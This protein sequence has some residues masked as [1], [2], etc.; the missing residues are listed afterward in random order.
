MLV[1]HSTSREHT[2]KRYRRKWRCPAKVGN[3]ECSNPCSTSNYG[4]TFYTS[5]KDNPRLFPRVK[6]DSKEWRTRYALRTGVE[7]CNK[8]QKIDYKL[9]ESKW[10]SSR[11]WTIRTY[12]IAMCQ[13]VDAWF[14]ETKKKELPTLNQW[15]E[16]LLAS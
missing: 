10:R 9:E 15:M 7:R 6:R 5:T 11:D 13:H 16:S 1:Y 14:K 2:S 12:L 8:R 3:W 4:R